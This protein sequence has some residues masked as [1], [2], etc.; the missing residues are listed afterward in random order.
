VAAGNETYGVDELRRVHPQIADRL[1][2]DWGTL[3]GLARVHP[4][5]EHES[6]G[7]TVFGLRVSRAANAVSEK[8]GRVARAMWREVFRKGRDEEV[9]IGH[10]TNGVHVATWMAEPMQELLEQHLGA[11]WLRRMH[12][13]AMWARVDAIPDEA[14]WSTRCALRARMVAYVRER[15]TI[16]RLARGETADYVELAS[17]AFDPDRL[18]FG[19]ARRLAAYKRMYLLTRNLPRAIQLLGADHRSIQIL[20]AG[21][22]HPQ[23][24]GAKNVVRQLFQAKGLP[25]VGERIAYLHDYDMAIARELVAGCDVWVNLPR[26]PLEA[27]GTSGMKAAL[28]GGLHLGVL[29]GWWSEGYD[30]QNG[31][32]IESDPHADPE[33]EDDRDA[34]AVLDVIEREIIPLFY[35]RDGAGIPRGWLSMVR[36]AIKTAGQR[37][38]AHRMLAD[39]VERVYALPRRGSPSRVASVPLIVSQMGVADGDQGIPLAPDDKRRQLGGQ[40]EPV[41]GAHALTT[42]IHDPSYGMYERV[43]GAGVFERTEITPYFLEVGARP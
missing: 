31:W 26:P 1:Q 9:P 11:D 21:K 33:T 38:G 14:L 8:H 18:T 12:D 7:M 22:A 19:F 20:L 40:V 41:G 17:R 3:F 29:D 32:A 13:P 16:D 36:A 37:F 24:D 30:G 35:D 34:N 23:D 39:Y 25:H 4:E 43:P 5:D 27:S 42:R 2:G 6:L 15:A 28:N 10:V